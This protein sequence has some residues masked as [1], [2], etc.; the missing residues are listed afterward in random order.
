MALKINPQLLRFLIIAILFYIGWTALYELW[1]HPDRT[2]ELWIVESISN[3]GSGA[4]KLMGYELI[5]TE[6]MIEHY[7][8]MGIDGTH[9]VY[10]SD[11]CAGLTLM[12]LFTG[13]VMAYPGKWKIKLIFIPI[14]LLTIHLINILRI[15]GLIL[16]TKH[17]PNLL[18]F[19]H[20]YTFT[21]VVYAYIF[22]L[23]VIWVN[24]FGKSA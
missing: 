4:L 24:K 8:T 11:S 18:D 20:H 21:F 19:N 5:T 6:F 10:I 1:I 9:G 12:A 2:L 23:W 15:I 22:I 13:F 16:L 17:A 3:I 14:G 7:R